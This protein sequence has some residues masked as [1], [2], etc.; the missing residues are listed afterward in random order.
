M[1]PFHISLFF[2]TRFAVPCSS[3]TF[4][5][6]RLLVMRIC[7]GFDVYRSVIGLE[8]VPISQP[9]RSKSK[10]TYGSLTHVFPRLAPGICIL[11]RF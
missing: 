1:F 2:R 11:F 9:I 3:R 10:T 6:E 8:N 5:N 7:F 4:G